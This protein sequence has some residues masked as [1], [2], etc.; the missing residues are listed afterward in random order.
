M[1]AHKGIAPMIGAIRSQAEHSARRGAARRG[2]AMMTSV[3]GRSEADLQCAGNYRGIDMKLIL[4]VFI[5]FSISDSCTA[6]AGKVVLVGHFSNQRVSDGEDPHLLSGYW[7]SFYKVDNKLFGDIGV[8][9]GA[10]EGAPGR[11][12]DIEFDPAT[13]KLRFK[14]KYSD[15]YEYSKQTS[16]EGRKITRSADFFRA[17]GAELL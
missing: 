12:S 15:G 8:A 10:G 5:L 16:P 2:V 9:M 3:A 7:V 6:D 11:L 13:K 1:L 17:A 4:A 14:A